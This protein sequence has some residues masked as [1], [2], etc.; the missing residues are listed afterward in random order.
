MRISPTL[1]RYIARHFF[2]NFAVVYAALILI[3]YLIDSLE[4]LRRASKHPDLSVGI[5]FQM[6]F[7][8]LPQVAQELFAFGILFSSM[9]T[10]WR[11]TR[12]HELI[13]ARAAGIGR[14]FWQHW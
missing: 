6:S 14:A 5:L 2:I 12:T 9:Y 3:V 11:L 1:T 10:F 4:L 7:L 8:Q 13:V